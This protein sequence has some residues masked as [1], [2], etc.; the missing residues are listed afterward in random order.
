MEMLD[1][2]RLG[3]RASADSRSAKGLIRA[4]T[5][6][7]A[8]LAWCRL[9]SGSP[10]RAIEIFERALEWARHSGD[11]YILAEALNH[12][13]ALWHDVGEFDRVRVLASE[14]Y[15]LSDRYDFGQ[16]KAIARSAG[17]W[18]RVRSGEP[19][20]LEDIALGNAAYR[21]T[22]ALNP[23]AYRS[24][25]RA[26]ALLCLGEFERGIAEVDAALADFRDNLDRFYDA[27]LH[28]IR[29]ELLRG[30]GDDA[31]SE[32][33]FRRARQIAAAQGA[34]WLEFRAD[35][36]LARLDRHRGRRA[37]ARAA[38]EPHLAR[39]PRS[40]DLP[41]LREARGLVATCD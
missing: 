34:R 7:P 14:T 4:L 24:A 9:L 23:L 29:G 36:G 3:D 13:L 22:G 39:Y 40:L 8:Y 26:E 19:G 6:T 33:C 18:A 5:S 28:R 35:L 11:P 21:S 30:A 41:D 10:D 27:E 20:G 16:W 1:E 2:M 37:D 17:G 38:L 32:E 25:Y 31:R 15:E 12:G